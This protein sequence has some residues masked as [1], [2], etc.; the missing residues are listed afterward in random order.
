MPDKYARYD[1]QGK[2]RFIAFID[3]CGDHSMDKIDRDFPLFVLSVVIVE[4]RTYAEKIVPRLNRFKLTYWDHEGINLHSRDIRKASGP[5][6]ILQNRKRRE[7]F[8]TELTILMDELPYT[9]FV[10]GIHKQRHRERYKDHARNPYKL[11]L[12]FAF[13]RISHFLKQ[14]GETHLPVIA[15]ARGRN[16]DRDLEA[17]FYQLLAQG[18]YFIGPKRFNNLCCPLLFK[19]KKKNICGLQMA[20]LCAYPSARH[21]L[22][23]T[24]PNHA[25]EVVKRHI[26]D[27]G[28][29]KGWKVFP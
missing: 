1:I 25:F 19:N 4:R 13:E 20:D 18:T 3:E 14:N 15:E 17:A 29:V 8:L 27:G 22:K 28:N 26:Y 6:S 12:T 10:V 16:E 7:R 23:P 11:A 21:I 24:Q 2:S 5:F 9:L